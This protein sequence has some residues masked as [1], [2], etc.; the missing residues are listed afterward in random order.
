MTAVTELY[1]VHALGFVRL[2][3]VMLGD[4]KAA[5]DVVQDAFCG[6]YRRWQ[7]LD[8]SGKALQYVRSAVFN[9]CRSHLRGRA[10]AQRREFAEPQASVPSPEEDALL[11]EEHAEVLAALRKLP[12]RQ[13]EALVLRFFLDLS[14]PDIATAMQVSQG[15]VKSTTSRALTTLGRLLEETR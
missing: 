15:T 2:A 6:L 10:R 9:G 4:L 13:R 12:A 1:E 8:D 3:M 11:A 7:H 5:E 14:E